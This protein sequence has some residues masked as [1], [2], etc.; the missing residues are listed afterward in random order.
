M[1]QE[2]ADAPSLVARHAGELPDYVTGVALSADGTLVAASCANG[3]LLLGTRSPNANDFTTHVVDAH[4]GDATRVAIS[5]NA[6]V[7]ATGG[8]DGAVRLWNPDG[9][10]INERTSSGGRASGWCNDLAFNPVSGELAAAVGRAV[11][12]LDADGNST[13]EHE[14]LEATIDCLEWSADGRRLFVGRYGGAVMFQGDRRALKRFD[15]KGALLTVRVSPDGK[16]LASGNQ[17][18]SVHCWKVSD[19]SDLQ[20]TGYEM[21][22]QSIAWDATSR[23]LAIG[24]LSEISMWDFSG[25]GP[26]GS[27]PTSL[28]GFDGRVVGLGFLAAN[29]SFLL[30]ASVDGLVCLWQPQRTPRT[31]R[32]TVELAAKP[33]AFGLAARVPQCV[34]GDDSGTVVVVDVVSDSLGA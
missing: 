29:P 3:Q 22:I 25:K 26:R 7:V 23:Y 20:M 28:V 6:S 1:P 24:T 13:V 30:S 12:R 31:L 15:W 17:D 34:V 33:T 4:A 32:G 5:P 18:A 10:L 11:V 21:K 2:V 16:W 14:P 8:V 9:S 19:G 27:R